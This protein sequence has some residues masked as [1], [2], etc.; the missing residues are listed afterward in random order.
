MV[1]KP[2][3]SVI[4][5]MLGLLS[6]IGPFS[7]DMY[8]PGFQAIAM[9]LN[10][11]IDRIQLSLTSFFIGIASGQMIYGPLL[12]R[13]GRKKPLIVG[14]LIYII[15][16][17]G[18]A[19]AQSADTL[20]LLR[21]IQ[22]LGSCSGMVASRAM[23]RD[24]FS[25]K[26][27]AR[28]FSMLMLIIGVSPILAPTV[29]GYVLDYWGWHSIFIILGVIATLIMLGII[30]IL[31]ESKKP[32]QTMSLKPSPI[33]KN[34][35]KVFTTPQFIIFSTAGGLASSGMYAYLSGS[36]FVMM[37]I[38]GL[39]EKQ[40]GW[41]F[42]F[43][44]A[45]LII[46]SQL[47]NQILRRFKSEHVAKYALMIQTM[48]GLTL[49][50]LSITHSLQLNSTI[51][52]IFCFLACQGFIFPNTSALALNPFTDLA[53]SA[54]ALLG[55][56]Q[57]GIGAVASVLVSIFHNGSSLPMIAVM[58]ACAI[59]SFVVLLLSPKAD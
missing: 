11:P 3:K 2:R 22:A 6:A 36:P 49:L 51:L 27:T 8:L 21:F 5:I 20:I 25:T 12:D 46:S 37:E 58:A 55:S 34:F 32:D 42:G 28:I 15:A 26:E 54:S 43:I 31:P 17:I 40:Y 56:I 35:W 9:D 16:S 23:V 52:L 29:G 13:F 14:L 45:G 38:F 41:V 44:A 30:F 7:I 4:I 47:N 33:I 24:F 19:F 59:M 53:G 39:N 48:V 18:C 10:T 50:V 1:R 57:L